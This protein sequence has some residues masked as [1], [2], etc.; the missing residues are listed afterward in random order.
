[1]PERRYAPDR[2]ARR[3]TNSFAAATLHVRAA[4]RSCQLRLVEPVIAR[5]QGHR[6]SAID[7][8]DQRFHDLAD[9]DP[10]RGGGVSGGLRAFGEAPRFDD[11]PPALGCRQHGANVPV[12]ETETSSARSPSA[13]AADQRAHPV[14]G[15]LIRGVLA[16]DRVQAL[17]RP[18]FP[19]DSRGRPPHVSKENQPCHSP[20]STT[21][22]SRSTASAPEK[23]NASRNP[24]ATRARGCTSGCSPPDFGARWSA[25][26]AVVAASTTPSPSDTV[27]GSAP[28]SW[29]LGSS[30]RPDGTRIRSGRAGGVRT[31]RSTPR[32]SSSRTTPARRSRWREVRRSTS[33]TLRLATRSRPLV[34]QP[35]AR[36]YASVVVPPWSAT[37]LLPGSSTTCTSWSSRSCSAEVSACG[38]DWK[39][40]KRTTPSRPFRRPAGSPT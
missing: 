28:R 11:E 17:D 21:S 34:T 15:G 27:Q 16:R 38:T 18:P 4:Y 22:P 35:T 14:I 2:K 13:E 26:L 40:S 31:R 9:L 25:S 10:D 1:M 29:V 32:L 3:I 19:Y 6:R 7:D 5:H 30:G 24:L 23:G 39:A 12:H 37:S 8:E 33:S 20:A 36:T